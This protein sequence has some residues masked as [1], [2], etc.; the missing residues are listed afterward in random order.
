MGEALLAGWLS[1]SDPAAQRLASR[2][3]LAVV[4]T[5]SHGRCLEDRYGITVIPSATQLPSDASLVI[6]AVK[7]QVLP[8][9]L[10][11]LASS[12]AFT[13]GRPLVISIA[14]GISIASLE[15]A[16]PRAVPVIRAMPNMPLQVGE[17]A[18][19]VAKGSRATD[20]QLAFA[21][22]LFGL[23]GFSQ[24][25]QEDQIDAVCALS[26]SG[27][28]YFAYLAECLAQA[29]C[30]AG[31]SSQLSEALARQTL[32]GTGACLVDQSLSLEELRASVSS[33]GGTTLAALAAFEQAAFA[34]AVTAGFNAA[35][36]RAKEL[37]QC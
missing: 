10:E 26:G 7:P 34:P 27:P 23:L 22:Q 35:I 9:V 6:L 13:E 8:S 33:P 21:N 36:Q 11:E 15:E 1:S 24:V 29:G 12:P 30:Q 5:A 20:A 3:F 17:G 32:A 28:A 37:S 31:L 25:V 2:G 14:A 18:S 4:P 16:L 19:V